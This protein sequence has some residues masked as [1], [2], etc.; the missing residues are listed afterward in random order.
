MSAAANMIR[1]YFSTLAAGVCYRLARSRI[2]KQA[3]SKRS[4][5]TQRTLDKAA[6]GDW[7]ESELCQQYLD[8]FGTADVAGLDVLDFGCGQGALSFLVAQRGVRSVTGIDIDAEEIRAAQA[9]V[10]QA[11]PGLQ[12][13]F[14]CSGS[15]ASIELPEASI[16]LIVC[17]DVLEHIIEY[18]S[19]IAEWRRVLRPGG[20]VFIWWMPWYHP[21]GH[22]IRRFVPLPW[23]HVVFSEQVLVETCIRI[24]NMPEYEPRFWEIDNTGKKKPM[25]WNEERRLSDLNFLTSAEFERICDRIGLRIV[26]R[27]FSGLGGPRFAAVARALSTVPWLR[28]FFCGS[29]VYELRKQPDAV[30]VRAGVPGSA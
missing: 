8:N 1:Q 26:R 3:D 24:Y 12:P 14:L 5:E 29:V 9:Q 15:T 19:I 18:R 20:R 2:L 6:Y 23:A 17:F 11:A 22:H 25:H 21:Y 30:Q 13:R 28:D 16:D 10:E 7:R 4:T 27:E